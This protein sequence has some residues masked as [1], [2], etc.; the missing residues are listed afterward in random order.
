[1]S[2]CFGGS[3]Q[4]GRPSGQGVLVTGCS[5]GIGRAIAVHLAEQGFTVFATV[6]KERDAEALRQLGN[7]NLAPACPLDL[8]RLTDIP[9]II[10]WVTQELQRRGQAGLYA[11]VNNAGGGSIAPIELL[12]V[13]K[14]RMEAE[15]R[16]IGPV[17]LL[18]ACLPLIRQAQGRVVWIVTPA[19]LPIRYVAS[20]HAYDFAVNCLARTLQLELAPWNIP[21]IQIRCGGIQTAAPA[22]TRQDFAESLRQW[23]PECVERYASSLEHEQTML[24]EFD[25][26]RTDPREVAKVVQR[27]LCARK[28]KSRYQI[29][30]MAGIAALAEYLPQPLLDFVMSK[31]A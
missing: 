4:D 30:Y 26:Q 28:P 1:M 5:S 24:A 23:P 9:P 2:G 31:R 13:N 15:T 27:A 21:S 12:D 19:L 17:A 29:G 22:K 3:S 25:M 10:D 7:P 8:T 18:Q 16:L 11:V 6:R 14:F 20:I